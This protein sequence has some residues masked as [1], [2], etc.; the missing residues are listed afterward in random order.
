MTHDSSAADLIGYSFLVMFADDGVIDADELHFLER[1]A[2]SDGEIDDEERA[3]LRR[4]FARADRSRMDAATC[5]EIDAFRAQY[6]L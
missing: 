6:D 1:V 4:I 2:L 5:A 3:A